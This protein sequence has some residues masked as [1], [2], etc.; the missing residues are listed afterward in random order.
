MN[1]PR[2]ASGRGAAAPWIENRIV[3]PDRCDISD[4][5]VVMVVPPSVV[6]DDRVQHGYSADLQPTGLLQIG[7]LLKA[8]GCEVTLL[9]MS[10]QQ[11]ADSGVQQA[12]PI[13][14]LPAGS[15]GE[16]ALAVHL[17]G[18]TFE[19]LEQRLDA[20]G[21]ADYVFVSCSIMYNY[22]QAF[23]AI[24]RC[25]QRLPDAVI[26]LGGAYP[27][28]TPEHA[29]RSDADGIYIGAFRGVEAFDPDLALVDDPDYAIFRLARGCRHSCS[30]CINGLEEA[31][32]Y[33]PDRVADFIERARSEYGIRYAANWD[34]NVLLFRP[35]VDRF[36][37]RMQR[38]ARLPLRFEM[39]VQPN[40]VDGP[41][42]EAMAAAGVVAYT[43]PFESVHPPTLRRMRKPYTP[44]SSIKAL[45]LARQAGFETKGS[46]CSFLVGYPGDPVSSAIRILCAVLHLG[47][48]PTPFPVT[49]VPRSRD[50]EA[51]RPQIAAMDPFRFNGHLWPLT[52]GARV[53]YMQDL[54]YFLAS[55]DWREA[56]ERAAVLEDSHRLCF[57]REQ[58]R[59]A[60]FVAK[61]LAARRDSY[62]ELE[63]INA[64]MAR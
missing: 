6:V 25:R 27:S 11:A 55:R 30:F 28:T 43:V 1:Q 10:W 31:Q 22:P 5:R 47:G 54:L 61:C 36:L 59:T 13:G 2:G 38:A 63:K 23:E 18:R 58:R 24:E 48:I 3:D 56:E 49:I 21:G 39:G 52:P 12:V 57:E 4:A 33:D 34:P 64:S 29:L 53:P 19:W 42:V 40:L 15:D 45:H 60:D 35:A 41:L 51:Y 7:A 8:Q 37:V 16:A 32:S 9:D 46:H 44:I 62:S 14:Q 26:L 50:F 20:L 17:P